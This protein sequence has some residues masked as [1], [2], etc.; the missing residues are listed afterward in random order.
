M[1]KILESIRKNFKENETFTP[2]ELNTITGINQKVLS[3]VLKKYHNSLILGFIQSVGSFYLKSE[4]DVL[5]DKIKYNSDVDKYQLM[6]KKFK[7]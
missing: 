3:M 2:S 6:N 7:V 5:K 1:S 4:E